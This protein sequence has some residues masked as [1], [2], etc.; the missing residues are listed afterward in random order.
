MVVE[1]I[2]QNE[3]GLTTKLSQFYNAL[4]ATNA[5]VICLT[6]TWLN[7]D[8]SNEN[9]AHQITV[10]IVEIGIISSVEPRW[11]VDQAQQ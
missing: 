1:L 11:A 7:D 9:F 10:C 8:F 2:Y 5:H 6:E 3:R 4:S